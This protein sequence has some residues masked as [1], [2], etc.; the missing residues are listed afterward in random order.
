M[1][2]GSHFNDKHMTKVFVFRKTKAVTQYA[3]VLSRH[4][5][6]NNMHVFA[7]FSHTF[8]E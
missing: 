7:G 3:E 5:V 8:S 4:G 6:A 1:L 2:T